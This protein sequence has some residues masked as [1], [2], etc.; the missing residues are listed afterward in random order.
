M[1]RLFLLLAF[2]VVPAPAAVADGCPPVTCGMSSSAV[3][4]SRMLALRPNGSAGPLVAYDLVTGTKRF[5]LGS[6]LLSADGTRFFTAVQQRPDTT[7]ARY[8]ARTGAKRSVWSIRGRW[9]LGAV[10]ASGRWLVAVWYARKSTR[11]A[12][13]DGLRGD[14]RASVTL[15]GNNQ[16]E[17]VSPNGSRLFLVHYLRNGYDLQQYDFASRRLLPTK[18]ADPDEKMSG[19]AWGAVATRNARW[20]LTLYLKPDGTAFVHALDLRS[21]IAHCIDLPEAENDF[22]MHGSYTMSLSPDERTLYMA[23]AL[24]GVVHSVDLRR[25]RVARSVEFRPQVSGLEFG[26]GPNSAVSPNGRMVYFSSGRSV[27]AYDAAYRKV[28]GP[29]V[30]APLNQG[31]QVATAGLGFTPDGRRVVAIRN[32]QEVVTLDAATGRKIR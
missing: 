22:A 16:V 11:L 17:S 23:N 6:G 29:Y 32:D 26:V 2:L 20:L 4:G 31:A 28:R 25:L 10:S 30:V 24:I 21:G 18:L 9:S 12:I 3:P 5:V 15:H 7:F 13:V 14:L 1:K 8:D 19:V 27:W